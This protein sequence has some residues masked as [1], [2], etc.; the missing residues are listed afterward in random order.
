MQRNIIEESEDVQ[1]VLHHAHALLT[2]EVRLVPE[3]W[4]Q[5][6]HPDFFMF[7]FGGSEVTFEDMHEHFHPLKGSIE[8]EVVSAEHLT[9]DVI[10][11]R[12]KG[13]GEND[14]VVNRGAVW[15]KTPEGWK[16]RYQQG[17]RH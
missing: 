5:Y 4:H 15:L 17:S 8:M 13:H 11:V 3:K 1:T 2:D 7:G 14:V 10:L 6:V 16:L 9:P 12:W